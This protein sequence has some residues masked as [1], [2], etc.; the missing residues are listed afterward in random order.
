ELLDP[1]QNNAFVDHYLD[2]PVD[3]SG[4]LFI[5]TANVEDTI[6][7]PLHDRMEIIRLS[8]YD[9]PEK[10]AIAQQYLIPK[11]MAETGLTE[12][13]AEGKVRIDQ[14]AVDSL[15]RWYCRESGVRNLEKHIERICRKLA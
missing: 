14:S 12:A 6:P 1:N 13:A 9:V 5:C 11:A 3:L 8:G 15:V 10:V 7:G 4:V 2:V